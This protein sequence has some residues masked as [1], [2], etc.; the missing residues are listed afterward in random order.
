M[1]NLLKLY[2]LLDDELRGIFELLPKHIASAICE[3]RIRA[4]KP[5]II[6]IKNTPYFI[7]KSGKLINNICSDIV[8]IS[9]KQF[10]YI[11]NAACNNSFHSNVSTMLNGYVTTKDGLRIGVCSTAVRKNSQLYSIKDITSLSIRIPHQIDNCSGV[12][13]SSVY[14]TPFPNII[15]ASAPSGG[16]TTLLRDMCKKLSSGY[17]GNYSKVTVID[18]REEISTGFDVGINT[19]VIKC[20]TK[21]EGIELAVRTLSPQ[22]IVCDE[23]GNEDEVNAIRYG[24]SSGVSFIVTVHASSYNDLIKRSVVQK[25]IST[26]QF[27]YIVLLKD[28]TNDYEIF[29]ITGEESENCRKSD[30]DNFFC[31]GGNKAYI[32]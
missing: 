27:K 26:E 6:Y 17:R 16:K 31:Y 21:K 15:I 32:I 4:E 5:L 30:G 28:Y 7:T 11:V 14:D 18:E 8:L 20:F 12:I 9:N 24:F 10:E 29:D 3:V 13:L 22:I 23:I 2:K 25:L 1:D 19:D